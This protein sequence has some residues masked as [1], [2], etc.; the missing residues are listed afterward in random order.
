M[1]FKWE[2]R[3]GGEVTKPLVMPKVVVS[4]T[5]FGKEHTA[6]ATLAVGTKATTDT[7]EVFY[8]HE[9]GTWQEAPPR[10]TRGIGDG[11]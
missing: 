2:T 11:G 3:Q 5:L 10:R 7:G 9:D 4:K 8:L 1:G 6:S